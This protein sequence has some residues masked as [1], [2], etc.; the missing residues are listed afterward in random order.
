MARWRERAS[1]RVEKATTQT[2][3]WLEREQRQYPEVAELAADLYR[4]DRETFAS[5]LGS[6]LALRLFLFVVAANVLLLGLTNLLNLEDI[7]GGALTA[8]V[9]T[10][11]MAESYLGTNFWRSLWM[12]LSGA[13]GLLWA[14]RTMTRTL[15]TCSASAWQLPAGAAKVTPRIILLVTGLYTALVFSA[16]IFSR[17][18]EVGSVVLW[19]GGWAG[20]FTVIAV[21]GFV[22]TY[23]LPRR[24]TDPGALIPGT[25]LFAAGFSVI[26]WFMQIYLPNRIARTEDTYGD[27]AASVAALG[28]FFYLGRL[29]S[30]SFVLNATMHDRY[31]SVSSLVFKLPVV[32]RIPTRWPRVA[33]FFELDSAQQPVAPQDAVPTDGPSSG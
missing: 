30:S 1:E 23:P 10:G 33:H 21:G 16:A 12:T 9:T 31:G 19:I 8:T 25:V 18:R 28:Y 2:T 14:G 27:L 3:Q 22:T 26:Q 24:G 17:A 32:R 20:V 29:L 11:P 13:V 15:A 5:V 7:L 4:R 6:A